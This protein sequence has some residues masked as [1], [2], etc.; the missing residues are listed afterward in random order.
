MTPDAAAAAA[1]DPA[2]AARERARRAIGDFMRRAEGDLE[3]A[4]R[5]VEG[6][7]RKFVKV[8]EYFGEDPEMS[9]QKVHTWTRSLAVLWP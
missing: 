3:T 7:E 4:R 5:L 1:G 8:L 6:A 9:P 2:A